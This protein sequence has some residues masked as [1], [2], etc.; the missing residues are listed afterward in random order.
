MSEAIIT[1]FESRYALRIC[2]RL[3]FGRDGEVYL[4]DRNTAVKFSIARET[5]VRERGVYEWLAEAKI[6]QIAGHAVPELIRADDELMAIEMTVVTPPFILDF[7]SA[8]PVDEAPDFPEDA[9]DEWR[10]RKREEFESLWPDVEFVLSEFQRL[11]G[12]VL[13]DVNSGNIRFAPE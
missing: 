3:G 6:T 13:L 5:F 7:A 12:F 11:T 1:A 8:Y 10:E 2:A 9:W 4:T